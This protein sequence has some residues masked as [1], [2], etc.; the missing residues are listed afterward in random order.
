MN[1]EATSDNTQPLDGA[2]ASE[3]DSSEDRENDNP[4]DALRAP[5]S[6]GDPVAHDGYRVA[7]VKSLSTNNRFYALVSR[8]QAFTMRMQLKT[9]RTIS[10]WASLI[11][12]WKT[13]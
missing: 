4:R 2:T 13:A 7:L 6:Q 3:Q 9:Y 5:A 10:C 8:S 1:N 11:R 12:V